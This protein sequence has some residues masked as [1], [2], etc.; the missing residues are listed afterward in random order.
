M[1]LKKSLGNILSGWKI[2]FGHMPL[3]SHGHHGFNEAYQIKK[4][5]ELLLP[6]LC[7][8]RVDFYLSGHDHHLEVDQYQCDNGH[9]LVAVISGAAAKKRPLNPKTLLSRDPNL[10]WGNGYL[11]NSKTGLKTN[12]VLGFSYLK[13]PSLEKSRNVKSIKAYLQMKISSG[14]GSDG[15]FM[16]ERGTSIEES[17][18]E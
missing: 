13:L 17:A 9:L 11:Y 3:F 2:V 6:L 12:S 7:D 16:I 1:W 4:F 8:A 15:C 5:R 18:C 14:K 10:V